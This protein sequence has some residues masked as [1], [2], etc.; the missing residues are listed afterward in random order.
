MDFTTHIL[1]VGLRYCFYL[2][3]DVIFWIFMLSMIFEIV[4]F[5]AVIMLNF[6]LN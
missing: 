2:S 5:T 3:C 4:L 1:C 6:F